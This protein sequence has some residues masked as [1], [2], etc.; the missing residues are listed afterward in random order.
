M[1]KQRLLL[2][3]LLFIDD[4][5]VAVSEKVFLIFLAMLCLPTFFLS[6]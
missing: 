6:G 5:N 3:A 2:I 1:L 4:V